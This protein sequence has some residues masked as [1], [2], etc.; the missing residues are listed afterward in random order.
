MVKFDIKLGN[1]VSKTSQIILKKLT[2]LFCLTPDCH[3]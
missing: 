1:N 2:Q 3:I